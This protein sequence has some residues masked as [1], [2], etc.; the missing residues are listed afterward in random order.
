MKKIRTVAPDEQNL[1]LKKMKKLHL[2]FVVI[3]MLTIL[4]ILVFTT[5]YA[6]SQKK[7]VQTSYSVPENVLSILKNSCTQC[8]NN[9]GNP[10]ASSHWSYSELDKYPA[11]KLAKKAS[12]MCSAITKGI[13]PPAS[14]RKNNPDRIPTK[15]QT[16]VIC[17]WASSIKTK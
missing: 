4:P 6:V 5:S 1:N 2:T 8:H 13:M 7:I 11:A 14:V 16:D 12:A 17:N 10:M 3:S 9:G 15:D